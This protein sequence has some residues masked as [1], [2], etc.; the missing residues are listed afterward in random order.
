MTMTSGCIISESEFDPLCGDQV[1]D[2]QGTWILS[3]EGSRSKC[4]DSDFNTESFTTLPIE[5]SFVTKTDANDGSRTFEQNGGAGFEQ[6]DFQITNGRIDGSCVFFD[7]SEPRVI[8]EFKGSLANFNSIEGEFT[9]TGP[10][11]CKS[12]GTFSLSRK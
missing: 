6:N 1:A 7:V 2:I 5:W 11:T 4:Q 3:S 8:F 9:S 10:E 12:E